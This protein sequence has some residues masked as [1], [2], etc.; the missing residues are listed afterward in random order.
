[1]ADFVVAARRLGIL[2]ALGAVVGTVVL[3]LGGRLVM[4][5]LS[6]ASSVPEVFSVG[7]SLTVVGA[8]ALSGA[9]G[10]LLFAAAHGITSR[11]TPTRS[12][13]GHVL[14]GVALGLVT[15]RGLRGTASA[16]SA[17]FVPLVAAYGIIVT[18]LR[19]ATLAIAPRSKG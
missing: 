16:L 6:I 19:M 2:V 14:F 8:G 15:L 11:L 10:A 7:G 13:V 4:R 1:M 5:L 18:R 9:A 17:L 3:G 12:W